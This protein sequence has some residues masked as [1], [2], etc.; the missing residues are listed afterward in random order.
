[1]QC[2]SAELSSV[3]SPAL[4]YFPKLSHKRHDFRKKKLLKIKCVFWFSQQLLFDTF[5][6]WEEMSAMWSEMSEMWSEMY[7]GLHVEYPLFVLFQWIFNFLVRFSKN[8]EISC[9]M[10]IRPLGPQLSHADGRTDRHD[11]DGILFF[12]VILR[13]RVK[14]LFYFHSNKSGN[15]ARVLMM[16]CCV[17]KKLLLLTL[18]IVV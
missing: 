3:A 10:K 1:M 12:F 16:T 6:F 4:K 2:A 18:S 14:F 11:E 13:K 17:W 7:I 15:I 8:A 5:P 9:L